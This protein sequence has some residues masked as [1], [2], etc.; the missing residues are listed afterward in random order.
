MTEHE[1]K[2]AITQQQL[3]HIGEGAVAYMR[4]MD[5]EDLQGKFPGMP[6]LKPGTR[7]WALFGGRWAA[8]PAGRCARRSARRRDAE[9]SGNCQPPLR[10]GH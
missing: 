8:D 9:R 2:F 10:Q 7:L 1:H 3:A 4:E 5:A 6:D